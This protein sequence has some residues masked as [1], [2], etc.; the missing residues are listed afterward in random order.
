MVT[1]TL[2]N[3]PTIEPSTTV[4]TEPI[5]R[6][7]VEHYHAMVQAGILTDD[8]P[9]ELL[10][11]WLVVKMTKNPPHRVITG[12]IRQALERILPNG[13]YVD[14][15]E[16]ITT[17][18]SEPEPDVVIVRGERIDYLERHPGPEDVALVVEVADATVRRDRG[19]KKRVYARAGIAVYWLVNLV[20]Q[21]IEVYTQPTQSGKQPDYKQSHIYH[22]DD[23]LPVTLNGVEIGQLAVRELLPQKG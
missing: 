19:T 1:L 16:P 6:L 7:S 4:P 15:Q 11:G 3:L 18:D 10:E 8:D 2:P 12:L 13:W 9:I 5:G 21:Q 22:L 23:R 14:S 17:N 20:N